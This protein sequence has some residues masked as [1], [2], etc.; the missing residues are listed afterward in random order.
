MFCEWHFGRKPISL[1]TVREKAENKGTL[2]STDACKT[3]FPPS[4]LPE[5]CPTLRVG[6]PVGH[7]I[8]LLAQDLTRGL[9][10][11]LG[12]ETGSVVNSLDLYIH[13]TVPSF[14]TLVGPVYSFY[15]S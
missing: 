6:V 1:A 13:F 2:R 7:L 8:A 5:F 15:S 3:G 12:A 9:F 10:R 14:V 11:F 4:A